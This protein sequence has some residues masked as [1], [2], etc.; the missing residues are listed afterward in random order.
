[1]DPAPGAILRTEVID[2]F[3]E[4]ATTYRVLYQP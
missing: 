3:V 4:G 1:L 2:P